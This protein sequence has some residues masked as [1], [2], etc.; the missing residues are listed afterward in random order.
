VALGLLL[1]LLSL[2]S[3]AHPRIFG[4]ALRQLI[5]VEAWRQG[6]HFHARRVQGSVFGDPLVLVQSVWTRQSPAGAVTRVEIM[7]AE[8]RFSW[9]D[10]FSKS[11]DRWIRQLTLEGVSGKVELPIARSADRERAA[12]A[13]QAEARSFGEQWLRFPAKVEARDVTFVFQTDDDFVRLDETSFTVSE[14]E[15]G[16]IRAGRVRIRQ[17]WLTRTFRNVEGTTSMQETRILLANLTL[18]PG[19]ENPEPFR[20]SRRDGKRAAE[21]RSTRECLCREYSERRRKRCAATTSSISKPAAPLPESMSH[22]WPHFWDSPKLPAAR[23]RKAG[24][25]FVDTRDTWRW[26]LLRSGSR[27]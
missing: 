11:Q 20:G 4:F 10:F 7:R 12:V 27:R 23:S 26:R 21:S 8:A 24:S 1:L 16:T 3:L 6:V 17:P 14:L 25:P 13:V 22:G 19:V 9:G 5:T 15:P 2:A 18:E